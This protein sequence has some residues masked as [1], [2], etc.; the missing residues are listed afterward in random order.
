M[1]LLPDW[2]DVETRR[3][4]AEEASFKPVPKSHYFLHDVPRLM[5]ELKCIGDASESAT[6]LGHQSM[7]QAIRIMEKAKESVEKVRQIYVKW[8]HYIVG[9][10]PPDVDKKNMCICNISLRC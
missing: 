3:K 6:K 5:I 7:I 8:I 1:K 2:L 10:L 9:C 4:V